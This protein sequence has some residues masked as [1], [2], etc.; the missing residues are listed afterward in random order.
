MLS[1]NRLW[2]ILAEIWGHPAN[3]KR[4]ARAVAS[5]I[6]WQIGKRVSGRSRIRRFPRYALICYPDSK[7]ASAAI[8][9][10]GLPDLDEMTFIERFLRPGDRFVD[11]GANIGLYT[12]FAAGIVG[13]KGQVIAFESDEV[14]RRRIA[15]N[16]QLNGFDNI[17]V[18]REAITDHAGSIDFGFSSESCTRRVAAP[19]DTGNGART[20]PT[21]TLCD[22]L[23]G[24][25]P[26][27]I[28]IDVEGAEPIIL[29][30]S[31]T[32][33]S[34][35]HVPVLQLELCG[36]SK[37][38][39]YRSD[40][41][42]ALL[43]SLGFQTA[44]YSA[45]DAKLLPAPEPWKLGRRDVLAVHERSTKLVSQRLSAFKRAGSNP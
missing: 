15:E 3:A 20:V 34:D 26:T 30:G 19:G 41:V 18:R 21:N 10:N 25:D 36:Y 8:Y 33:L 27:M 29:E 22:A 40:Q 2:T 6:L 31:R 11:I 12:L 1:L 24:I 4:R 23:E 39:G 43:A 14:S 45:H 32:W 5:A 44:V 37:K 7:S 28:K 42:V 16:V 13:P 38:Y 35:G 9:F 17:E